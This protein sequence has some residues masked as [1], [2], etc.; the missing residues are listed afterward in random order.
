M[1]VEGKGG[2]TYEDS[3]GFVRI[4]SKEP[5]VTPGGKLGKVVLEML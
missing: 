2:A 4:D 1:E 3:Q 5:L